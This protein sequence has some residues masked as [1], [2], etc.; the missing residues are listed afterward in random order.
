MLKVL[1]DI[2]SVDVGSLIM[3]IPIYKVSFI[4]R[5]NVLLVLGHRQYSNNQRPIITKVVLDSLV[6]RS[7][8]IFLEV[9]GSNPGLNVDVSSRFL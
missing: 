6:L 8:L 1:G 9:L 7:V 3:T 2:V 5:N 4:D